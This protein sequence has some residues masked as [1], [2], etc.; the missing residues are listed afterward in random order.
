MS[1]IEVFKLVREYNAAAE[2]IDEQIF[3]DALDP[4][5]REDIPLVTWRALPNA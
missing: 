3:G 1:G 5:L 4:K 2:K